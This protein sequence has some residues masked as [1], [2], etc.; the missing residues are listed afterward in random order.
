MAPAL[1]ENLA[2]DPPSLDGVTTVFGLPTPTHQPAD[3]LFLADLAQALAAAPG[4]APLPQ[5]IHGISTVTMRQPEQIQGLTV[6]EVWLSDPN[7][8]LHFSV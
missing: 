4:E 8:L 2:T 6:D 7:E 5:S 3:R 1:Q